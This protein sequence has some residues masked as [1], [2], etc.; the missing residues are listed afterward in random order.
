MR[1]GSRVARQVSHV[2]PDDASFLPP[3]QGS[4]NRYGTSTALNACSFSTFARPAIAVTDTARGPAASALGDAS[5]GTLAR[6]ISAAATDSSTIA[7][8][9]APTERDDA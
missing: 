4:W 6:V 2:A 3:P 8:A 7:I 1:P 5:S 9:T